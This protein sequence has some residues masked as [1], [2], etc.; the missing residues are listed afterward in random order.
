MTLEMRGIRKSF[1]GNEV[2]HGVDLDV[3]PGEVHALVGHNGAGKSTLIKVLGGLYADYT[4]EISIDGKPMRFHEPQASLAAGVAVIQ[5]EFSLVPEFDAAQNLTLG[6][7]PRRTAGLVDHGAVQRDGAELLRRFG[8]Q[9]PMRVPS[10]RLSVAHQQLTEIAKALSREARI[11]VMDEPTSRLA[12]SERDALF[13][14]IADLTARGVAVIYISHFLDEVLAIA[15]HVTVLRDGHRVVSAAAST[16]TLEELAEHI[17]GRAVL[18]HPPREATRTDQGAVVL[19][20]V[21]FGQRGRPANDLQVRSGQVLGLAGLVG[22]GRSAILE[23]ICGARPSQGLLRLQGHPVKVA[24]PAVAAALGVVLVPEDRKNKGLV[25]QRSVGENIVLTALARR[26]SRGGLIRRPS[27]KAAVAEAIRR[28][29]IRARSSEDPVASLSGGN[30]QKTLL[31][32]AATAHPSVLLLDQPTAGV[33]I[34]AKGEIYRQIRE[35]AAQGV[36]C[37]VASDELKELL[38]LCDQVVVVR[39]GSVGVPQDVTSTDEATLLAEISSKG[40]HA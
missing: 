15:D 5:Q 32:R 31:A 24:S 13:G 9:I 28:F 25:M 1:L 21:G 17:V 30:Q 40:V 23:A 34:G 27:R 18:A 36:A 22:S 4:G 7:E 6:H 12:R 3:H 8:I 35:L 10:R 33:D 2:L 19:E 38:L 11:L 29:D 39:S 26:F 37:V 20:L 16:L 14:I